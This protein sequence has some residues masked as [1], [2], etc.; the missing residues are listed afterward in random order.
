MTMLVAGMTT[1]AKIKIVAPT[2]SDKLVFGKTDDAVVASAECTLGLVIQGATV[3]GKG[4]R[5]VSIGADVFDPFNLDRAGGCN[6]G[7]DSCLW[8]NALGDASADLTIH[9]VSLDKPMVLPKTELP[10]VE[11][12]LANVKIAIVAQAAVEMNVT[13]GCIA[14]V[15]VDGP[16]VVAGR[17]LCTDGKLMFEAMNSRCI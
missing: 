7:L 3:V 11:A 10:T 15:A 12:G 2:A 6:T 17:G 16:D 9:N 5:H 8:C 4:T 14:V 13:H 1:K